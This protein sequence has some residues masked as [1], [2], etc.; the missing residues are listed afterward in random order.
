MQ[1]AVAKSPIRGTAARHADETVLSNREGFVELSSTSVK[2]DWHKCV[3]AIKELTHDLHPKLVHAK[4]AK[5]VDHHSK[6]LKHGGCDVLEKKVVL[7]CIELAIKG[8]GDKTKCKNAIAD[9]EASSS[10]SS[11]SSSYDEPM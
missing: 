7:S 5:F 3:V 9:Q 4:F 2:V 11:S 10:S 8:S 1:A 6:E